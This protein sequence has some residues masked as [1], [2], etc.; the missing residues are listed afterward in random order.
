MFKDIYIETERLI[1]K[2]YCMEDIDDLY[3]AI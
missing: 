3:K 1:V 2:P